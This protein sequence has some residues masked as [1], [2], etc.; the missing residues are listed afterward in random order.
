MCI[1][2]SATREKL[3]LGQEA[4]DAKSNEITAIPALLERLAASGAL[5]G[6]LVTID[7]MERTFIVSDKRSLMLATRDCTKYRGP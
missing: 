7:A 3:V 6:A 1:R 2:D 5:E 4:I